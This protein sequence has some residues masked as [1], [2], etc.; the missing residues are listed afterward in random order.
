MVVGQA[1]VVVV[2]VK[3]AQA[4]T[5]TQ[6]ERLKRHKGAKIFYRFPTFFASILRLC[7]LVGEQ[8]APAVATKRQRV[9]TQEPGVQSSSTKG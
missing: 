1:T 6:D 5:H 4:C 2:V 9:E 7:S 8:P 3:R